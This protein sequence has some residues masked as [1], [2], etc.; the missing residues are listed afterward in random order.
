MREHHRLGDDLDVGTDGLETL[1]TRVENA[2]AG[3]LGK[4][5]IDAGIERT[6]LYLK[7]SNIWHQ[8]SRCRI[9]NLR[10]QFRFE[11]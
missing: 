2:V 10:F 8:A 1:Y 6:L 5:R 11:E 3:L 7:W 4:L 9:I